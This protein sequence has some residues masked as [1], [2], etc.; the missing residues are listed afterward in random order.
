MDQIQWRFCFFLSVSEPESLTL[1]LTHEQMF[2]LNMKLYVSSFKSFTRSF[3]IHPNLHIYTVIKPARIKL[4]YIKF[5]I[6]RWLSLSKP[7]CK[8]SLKIKLYICEVCE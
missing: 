3:K 8:S 2:F 6:I 7:V 1:T 5:C 4:I